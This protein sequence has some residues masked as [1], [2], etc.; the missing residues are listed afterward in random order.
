MTARTAL[1]AQLATYLP[2]GI[3]VVPYARAIDPPSRSTVMLRLDKVLPPA[4]QGHNRAE[5][6]LV[7]IAAK[8]TAGPGDDELEALLEDVLFALDR[9]SDA[10]AVT[11]TEA[12]RATYNETNPAF[13]VLTTVTTSKE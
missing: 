13:E 3:D 1:T 4:A 11:W 10:M 12:N 7:L 8:T 5:Y 2:A 6:A 9:M